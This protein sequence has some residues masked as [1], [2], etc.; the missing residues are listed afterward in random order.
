MT[1][2]C[3]IDDIWKPGKKRAIMKSNN[4]NNIISINGNTRRF[5]WKCIIHITR[6]FIIYFVCQYLFVPKT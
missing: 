2:M 1:T 5:Y 6:I 3:D 4:S